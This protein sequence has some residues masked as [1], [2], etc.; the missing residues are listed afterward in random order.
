MLWIYHYL[1]YSPSLLDAL[2]CH[3]TKQT[4]CYTDS[5]ALQK[6]PNLVV[7]WFHT[8]ELFGCFVLFQRCFDSHRYWANEARSDC[9]WFLGWQLKH[10]AFSCPRPV[11]I[12]PR[13]FL[14]LYT[15]YLPKV[16]VTKVVP[17]WFGNDSDCFE[18]GWILFFRLSSF[19]LRAI[20]SI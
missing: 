19:W 20:R 8:S 11:L 12:L 6:S 13:Y 5:S 1:V 9:V 14:S 2:L 3:I 16:V 7:G 15:G 17:S 4:S 10:Q 18:N